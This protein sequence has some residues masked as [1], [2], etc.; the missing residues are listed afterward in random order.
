MHLES[1]R[2]T[3]AELESELRDAVRGEVLVDVT[4]RG[5]YATD[6]SHYQ[7]MPTCVVLPRDEA[8]VLAALRIA[9]DRGLA[10][11][12]RG[13]GTSLSGQTTW[14]GMVL[15]F[16]K[17]MHDVLE[18]N[19]A[20]QWVRV[21]PGVVRDELNRKLRTTGLHFA[22]D[23]AT[24]SRAAV[25]GMVGNNTSGTRSI[26]YG[27]TSENIVSL[28]VALM[29]GTVCEFAAT[30]Q[31]AWLAKEARHDR[32]GELY[33]GI[34]ALVEANMTEIAARYPTVMRRVSG[35][36]LDAFLPGERGQD[37]PWNLSHLIV[38]SEGTLGVLLEAKLKLRPLPKA[39][40]VC[41]VHFKDVIESLAAVPAI[42]QHSP[43]AV[44]LLD[45]VILS[46]ARTNAATA[47]KADF[48]EGVP[49]AVQ[50][51][52]FLGETEEEA[53]ERAKAMAAALKSE[54]IG[55][56]SLVCTGDDQARVWE[57]RKLGLGLIS[58]VPGARKGIACIE[59]A[60]VPVEH[61]AS[62]IG[63]VRDVCRE[64]GVE[65]CLYAHASVGVIHARPLLDLH[66]PDDV[67]KMK[68]ISW[69]AFQLVKE[70][71]GSW[72]SEHGD[73][74]LRG[75]FIADFYGPKIAA[76]FAEVK[77]LFDPRGLMNP[78]KIVD[79]APM[80][81]LL[82]YDDRYRPAAVDSSFHYRDQGGFV[83]AVEQCAG[84]GAC[85]KTGGG[86]MCPSYMATRDEEHT[87]RGRANALRLAMSGQLPGEELTSDRLRS[88]LDLCLSCKACKT[89]CPTA[90]DMSR[91][92]SD[93]LQMRHAKFG[94]PLGAKVRGR[95]AQHARRFVGRW[96][97]VANGMQQLGPVRWMLERVA[98]IDRRR[99]L[100]QLANESFEQWFARKEPRQFGTKMRGRVA[101]F[102]DTFTNCFEPHVGQAAV[103]LL[104]ACGYQVELAAVGCCQRPQISQGLL[105]EARRD[106]ARTL[107]RLDALPGSDLPILVL[108]PSCASALVDDVPDL[109]DDEALG[110]RVAKRV[111]LVDA[112]LSAEI[113]AGRLDVEFT[114][115]VERMLVHGHCHQKAMFGTDSMHA[116][117][118]RVAGLAIEEVDSGCC[119]M[120]GSFGYQ[121][122]DLSQTIGEDR[123]FPAVRGRTEG[124]E[125]VACG[126]SCRH[127]LHDFLNVRAKHWVEL[128]EVKRTEP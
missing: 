8:D 24:G 3:P 84:I 81:E 43:S 109:V 27:K 82:R 26:V 5:I 28:R 104:E 88:V 29:D 126:I 95:V 65:L 10:V 32:E 97:R 96:S 18:V 36:A 79:P 55:Y 33:R 90:V 53:A 14:T 92:K 11:T 66:D 17:F 57:V 30:S 19:A 87:T 62:Y 4:S 111:Q 125:V 9:N 1:G 75:E 120:A 56:A 23:P 112:F 47:A 106:G 102:C 54:A 71:D 22:P 38:G 118:G 85:R 21:Q 63:R 50:I 107:Q 70:Y 35:Y 93:V 110:S 69:A 74:L 98:G 48:F 115:N 40:A 99:P 101:L 31:E 59:D 78:G 13:G 2:G 114:A 34:R 119:G 45:D 58:N 108:E 128:V 61:L 77:R 100:P 124:T 12:A 49:Q 64:M 60:S 37:G 89:E 122:F 42:L 116:V 39:A 121:H 41:V 91:L 80:T 52:E 83:L 67:A 25:G 103:E 15:D 7:V 51:V 72:A 46:E 20:E 76:A 86:T 44:E 94:I 73:G 127:Q 117:L 6:A 123:L 105:R 16:T 68:Q 113:A